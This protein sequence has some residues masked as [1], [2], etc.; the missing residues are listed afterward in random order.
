MHPLSQIWSLLAPEK[1]D[2]DRYNAR[3]EALKHHKPASGLTQSGGQTD[4]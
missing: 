1:Q 4:S 2:G 3:L